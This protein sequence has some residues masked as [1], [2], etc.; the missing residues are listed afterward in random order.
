MI[1]VGNDRQFSVL[2]DVLGAPALSADERFATNVAR[3]EHRDLLRAEL[4]RRLASRAAADWAAELTAARVPA[5]VVNDIGAAFGLAQALGLDPIVSIPRE[6]GTS[7]DLTRNPIGLSETPPDVSLGAAAVRGAV[8]RPGAGAAA[9]SLCMG[10]RRA[11][12]R[13]STD[14]P[15]AGRFSR[16]AL[17]A[18]CNRRSRVSGL[19]AV[20]RLWRTA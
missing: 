9:V 20:W 13:R 6:D 11:R 8:G 18:S 2:C 3:V 17:S 4:E 7:V 10:R 14:H 15:C 19:T 12:G 16:R 5:G 1:A